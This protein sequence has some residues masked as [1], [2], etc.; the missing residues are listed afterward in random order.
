MNTELLHS[1]NVAAMLKMAVDKEQRGLYTLL[2]W[3]AK[4]SPS[5]FYIKA[6]TWEWQEC[7]SATHAVA[8]S[9]VRLGH[10]WPARPL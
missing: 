8:C 1:C 6:L 7:H 2:N 3:P 4:K 5:S 9:L 10:V